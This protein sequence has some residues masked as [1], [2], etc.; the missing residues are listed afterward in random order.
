MDESKTRLLESGKLT[1]TL[2]AGLGPVLPTVAVKIKS[3]PVIT[4]WYWGTRLTTR[5]A[6]GMTET[7]IEV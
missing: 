4:V 6:D 1:T 7:D 5:L 3:C 2:V